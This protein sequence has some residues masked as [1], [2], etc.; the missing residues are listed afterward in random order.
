MGISYAAH[1]KLEELAPFRTSSGLSCQFL[2]VPFTR[3]ETT[4]N[5]S[6]KMLMQV[7]TLLTM[8]DSFTP[9]ASKPVR[10]K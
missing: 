10:E 5:S 6:T 1:L 3:P 8:A 7:N 9:K 2:S 4:M